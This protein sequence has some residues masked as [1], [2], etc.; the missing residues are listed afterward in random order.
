MFYFYFIT[1]NMKHILSYFIF[2]LLYRWYLTL[3][4]YMAFIVDILIALFHF[5]FLLQKHRILVQIFIILSMLLEK[6]SAKS[7]HANCLIM[8]RFRVILELYLALYKFL[9]FYFYNLKNTW[10]HCLKKDI[11]L[12]LNL[13]L[14]KSTRGAD[15]HLFSN[16]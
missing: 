9:Y 3:A 10:F 16:M 4:R 15:T 6:W 5:H 13:M 1:C 12:Y 2:H 8:L 11:E 7:Y 14:T